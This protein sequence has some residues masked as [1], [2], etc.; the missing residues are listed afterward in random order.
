MPIKAIGQPPVLTRREFKT[1]YKAQ[2]EQMTGERQGKLATDSFAFQ[3][4]LRL[5]TR[6]VEDA[7][8]GA[9]STTLDAAWPFPSGPEHPHPLRTVRVSNDQ[10]AP[11]WTCQTTRITNRTAWWS[12]VWCTSMQTMPCKKTLFGWGQKD[13]CSYEAR[14]ARDSNKVAHHWWFTPPQP[15]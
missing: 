11:H 14:A 3:A 5:R 4:Y 10:C 7:A 15:L 12:K 6:T 8:W 1:M 9:R 2:I 13:Q